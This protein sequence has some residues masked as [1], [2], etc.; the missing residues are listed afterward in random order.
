M[1]N[2][3]DYLALGKLIT[4]CVVLGSMPKIA[5]SSAQLSYSLETPLTI[6]LVMSRLNEVSI[7]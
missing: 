1:P 5:M 3:A 4:D 7:L 2:L 6:F